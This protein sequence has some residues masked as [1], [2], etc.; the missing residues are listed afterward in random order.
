MLVLN[1]ILPVQCSVRKHFLLSK[2]VQLLQETGTTVSE[3]LENPSVVSL[4][5]LGPDRVRDLRGALGEVLTDPRRAVSAFCTVSS[6]VVKGSEVSDVCETVNELADAILE[7]CFTSKPDALVSEILYHLGLLKSE[8]K[9]E[10]V[11]NRFG[12]LVA[13]EHVVNQ[14]Y[15]PKSAVTTLAAFVSRPHAALDTDARHRL[16]QALYNSR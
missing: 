14:T 9:L 12:P 6:V 3:F 10:P 2:L 16:L 5:S 1:V 4:L 8:D 13:L 11:H 7:P 15:C